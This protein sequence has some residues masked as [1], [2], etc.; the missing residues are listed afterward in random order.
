L[1]FWRDEAC[2]AYDRNAP[3][4]SERREGIL[5]LTEAGIPVVLRIDPLFPRSPLPRSNKSMA[6]FELAEAQSLE[7]LE[8]LIMFAKDVGVSHIVYS[9]AR[10]VRPGGNLDKT[11]KSMLDVYREIAAPEKPEFKGNS[12]RL[13][14]PA[15]KQ[16]VVGPFLEICERLG[17]KATFC[18][19]DLVTTGRA[20]PVEVEARTAK[21]TVEF[22]R[23]RA[24]S[25]A[26]EKLSPKAIGVSV[27]RR[28]DIPAHFGEW[29]RNRLAAGYA[30]YSA[31][32][33]QQL[34]HRS[35][36]PEDVTHF[37]FWTKNPNP[38]LPVLAE[39]LEIGY[40]VIWNVTITGLGGT[41]VEPHIPPAKAVVA[42]V[43]QLAAMVGKSAILWRYDPI[44]LSDVYGQAFHIESF[45]R[46]AGELAG[47]VDRIAM[48]FVKVSKACDALGRYQDET[49]D[50]LEPVPLAAQVDLVGR[51]HDVGKAVGLDLTLCGG[52]KLQETTGCP[53]SGCNGFKWLSRVYPE[54]HKARPMKPRQTKKD[55]SCVDSRDIG[56]F[57]TCP[58]GCR[59][60]YANKSPEEVAENFRRHDPLASCLIPGSSSP[61]TRAEGNIEL[62]IISAVEGT[63]RARDQEDGDE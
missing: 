59:Y 41:P 24:G 6:N 33:P 63:N 10:I 22:T 37:V 44:F 36:R 34:Y 8:N 23:P 19:E 32:V 2:A 18:M 3:S 7:D 51:L 46:L 52:K 1:A 28:T 39:V 5:A 35:L 49:G 55:C 15:I 13:P 38:F 50:H 47:H 17:V 21:A 57:G 29:F 20:E 4:I 62:P 9:A 54:L 56:F 43:R 27:S 31:L 61:A 11:M 53:S 30:E 42:S 60:C 45:T 26:V 16:H 48:S 58:H 12:W 40:P 14:L 25:W